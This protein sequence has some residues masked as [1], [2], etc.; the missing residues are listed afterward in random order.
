MGYPVL[1]H[2]VRGD[3]GVPFLVL[4][5]GAK[6]VATSLTIAIGG[7]G[8]VFAPSLFMG[9]ALGMAYG[10][11]MHALLP[12]I[13]HS[14]GAYGLVG[15]G[16]VFAAASRA[17]ITSLLIIFEMTGDY[18]VIL[19]LMF[20]I[21]LA[22]PLSHLFSEDTIYTAKLR[23]R[24]IEVDR[25]QAVNPMATLM[26]RDAMKPGM[27]AVSTDTPIREAISRVT[28]DGRDALA[29]V[30]K[31]GRYRGVITARRLEETLETGDVGAQVGQ[32][33][34]DVPTITEEQNLEEAVRAQLGGWIGSPGPDR[35]RLATDR[36]DHP[37]G[38]ATHLRPSPRGDARKTVP[39]EEGAGSLSQFDPRRRGDRM[40]RHL[41]AREWR[42]LCHGAGQLLRPQVEDQDLARARRQSELVERG[43]RHG[44]AVLREIKT[45]RLPAVE[46]SLAPTIER[47]LWTFVDGSEDW[48]VIEDVVG[49]IVVAEVW[50]GG[51]G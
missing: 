13:A 49:D 44:V 32:P 16:A 34:E 18:Q 1:E 19:P 15:M 42:R 8:S 28:G 11:V 43:T 24:G 14:A 6:V 50:G 20:S 3:Y 35:R 9:A 5:V 17:P 37:P 51:K 36:M 29:V 39:S 21:A 23:R 31:H 27:H 4:L 47:T 38:R 41:F 12:G 45:V 40:K 7:S 2:A 33:T 46:A 26:V 48:D 10:Q 22:V 30:D 25:T